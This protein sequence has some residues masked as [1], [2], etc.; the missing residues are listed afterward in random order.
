MLSLVINSQV[1][2]TDPEVLAISEQKFH[3]IVSV[4]RS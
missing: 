4:D 1:E 2:I 3:L